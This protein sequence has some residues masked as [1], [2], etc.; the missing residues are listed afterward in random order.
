MI[1]EPKWQLWHS[2]Q[3]NI[4]VG[5]ERFSVLQYK[6]CSYFITCV[7]PKSSFLNLNLYLRSRVTNTMFQWFDMCNENYTVT[8]T[9]RKILYHFI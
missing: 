9:K 7:Q 8:E 5:N 3:S 2:T 6:D 4:Q 1:P